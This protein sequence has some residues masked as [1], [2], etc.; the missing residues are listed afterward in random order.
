MISDIGQK[1]QRAF[2]E[3]V[4][5]PTLK[6]LGEG[7][8]SLVVESGLV[9]R[10]AKNAVVAK[11]HQKEWK[12]LP[13]LRDQI[14]LQIPQP[15]HYVEATPDFPFGVIG[16]A[17]IEGTILSPDAVTPKTAAQIAKFLYQL[18]H[19]TL[20]TDLENV[21]PTPASLAQMQAITAPYLQAHLNSAEYGRIERWWAESVAFWEANAPKLVLIHGDAWY[22]N[23]V[24][25]AENNIVGVLD[26]E[27]VA[28]G[29]AAVDFVPQGYISTEFAQAVI[30]E[31]VILGG[32]V[33]QQLDERMRRLAGLRELGG[34]V[35]GLETGAVDADTLDKI[36]NTAIV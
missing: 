7:F 35:Y 9:W 3:V 29:D 12:L 27:N 20:D 15:A 23:F 5:W 36:R 25:D 13:L 10:I 11:N 28:V 17:K 16:Y 33:G 8:G 30:R 26:F 14:D 1:L 32:D 2:P 19:I 18:H 24:I 21:T 34:L 31:Y 4:D 22:E 6:P